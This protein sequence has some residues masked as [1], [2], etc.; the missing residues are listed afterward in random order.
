MRHPTDDHPHAG[1]ACWH[2]QKT[3]APDEGPWRGGK[4]LFSCLEMARA[5]VGVATGLSLRKSSARARQ[6]IFRPRLVDPRDEGD[7]SRE[8]SL[9]RAWVDVFAP[10]IADEY[11]ATEW[12]R[13]ISIDA[14]PLRVPTIE[15]DQ[16]R[17]GT[18]RRTNN[19]DNS[20][21]IAIAVDEEHLPP[22]PI[23]SAVI[24][25]KDESSWLE[26]L[27]KLAGKPEWVVCDKDGGLRAAIE[28]AW[29]GTTVYDCEAHLRLNVEKRLDEDRV[30]QYVVRDEPL[31]SEYSDDV[32]E[33]QRRKPKLF[34]E[35]KVREHLGWWLKSVATWDAWK[36][37]VTE[38]MPRTRLW[39]EENEPRVLELMALRAQ[40]PD[41]PTVTDVV[42]GALT[43]ITEAL[44]K[45][46]RFTNVERLGK[47]VELM[48]LGYAGLADE[49]S[50]LGILRRHF[51]E[52]GG[53]S[54]MTRASYRDFYDDHSVLS[55]VDQLVVVAR[56]RGSA[57]RVDREDAKRRQH[58]LEQMAALDTAAAAAG[59]PKRQRKTRS[60]ELGPARAQP[61][62]VAG[63][64]LTDPQ[65]ARFMAEWDWDE[66]RAR[67]LDPT[68]LPAG[69]TK[70]AHWVCRAHEGHEIWPHLHQW[71]T[72][73]QSRTR[74]D[75]ECPFCKNK[76]V[77]RLNSLAWV[78][79]SL[80]AEWNHDLNGVITPWDVLPGRPDKVLWNCVEPSSRHNPFPQSIASR[81]SNGAGCPECGR[82]RRAKRLREQESKAQA[83]RRERA[84]LAREILRS[85]RSSEPE[86]DPAVSPAA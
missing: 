38:E 23:L 25:S 74:N 15:E 4:Y 48:R 86:P 67:G 34:R 84:R 62:N 3:Y 1:E 16:D 5:L 68:T 28:T 32:P 78:R 85:L 75:S 80:A 70:K 39:I 79:P 43:A 73:I 77:C 81:Y 47:V 27:A 64:L 7:A 51:S 59:L 13:A 35:P 12:P 14:L 82:E 46:R 9:A 61:A 6:S 18:G 66:N 30:P 50:W 41:M 56:A 53:H 42:E 63:L 10:V 20:V 24:G 58:L 65:F 29:K 60:P 31:T 33:W 19:G 36:A 44:T 49:V 57:E 69:S 11:R 26:V 83:A 17:P 72:Q 2:C 71:E 8:A 55:S 37:L 40:N 54:G 22:R 21:L 76:K 52:M 45:S